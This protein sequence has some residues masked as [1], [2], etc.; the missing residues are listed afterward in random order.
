MPWCRNP[1]G[2]IYILAEALVKKVM[3]VG[4]VEGYDRS[5]HPSRV[6]L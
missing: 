3:E 5:G 1:N 6:L 2:E 4:G